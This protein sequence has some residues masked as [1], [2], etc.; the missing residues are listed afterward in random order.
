M[1]QSINCIV[2]HHSISCVVLH[3]SNS[4]TIL[5][6]SISCVVLHQSNSCTILRHS[7][8]C[9]VLH[10]SSSCIFPYQSDDIVYHIQCRKNQS[11]L[12]PASINEFYFLHPAICCTL[13]SIG[14]IFLQS[15]INELYTHTTINQFYIPTPHLV[16]FFHINSEWHISVYMPA[17]INHLYFSVNQSFKYSC[18]ELLAVY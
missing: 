1:R 5:C 11:V 9:V 8:S 3:Q 16:L 13:Q 4:C 2:L 7:I 6:H 12:F 15:I 14:C 18:A 10:Q 17:P